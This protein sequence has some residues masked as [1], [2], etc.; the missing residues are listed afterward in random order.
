MRMGEAAT[1]GGGAAAAAGEAAA[2]APGTGGAAAM[3]GEAGGAAAVV[4]A[5]DA[6]RVERGVDVLVL[7]CAFDDPAANGAF[8]RQLAL[9]A[10]PGSAAAALLPG[11]EQ[12]L[13]L[14]LGGL[15]PVQVEGLGP[16]AFDQGDA[17]GSRKMVQPIMLEYLSREGV[18]SR[19]SPTVCPSF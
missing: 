1:A 17:K 15:T 19:V 5:C 11:L 8:R 6:F 3:A 14:G 16:L 13:G 7:M 18:A 10:A 9:T 2:T 12:A 4:A